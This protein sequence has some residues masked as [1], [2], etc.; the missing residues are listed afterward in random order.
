MSTAQPN[1]YMDFVNAIGKALDIISG[2]DD[3]AETMDFWSY[4]KRISPS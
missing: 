2:E 3:I 4:Y 1:T